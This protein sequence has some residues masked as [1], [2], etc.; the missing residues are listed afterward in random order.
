MHYCTACDIQVFGGFGTVTG[1]TTTGAITAG[2]LGSARH[3][4]ATLSGSE[5]SF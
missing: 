3:Y 5:R 1:T 2:F 4:Y